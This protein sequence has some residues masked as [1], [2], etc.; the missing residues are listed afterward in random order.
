[1][2]SSQ[3]KAFHAVAATGSFT[4]AA[5]LLNVTQ[6]AVSDHV[7]KLEQATGAALFIR[8]PRGVSL[9]E[10]GKKLFALAE[11]NAETEQAVAA[12]LSQAKALEVG[13]LTIG[14]D[15]AA[16]VMPLIKKF[17]A[18]YPSVTLRIVGG[19]ST[20][21]VA[22]LQVFEIDFAV[23]G[24]PVEDAS[25]EARAISSDRLVA[26]AA[27]GSAPA[28]KASISWRELAAQPLVMREAGSHTRELLLQAFHKLAE[29][30]KVALE[31]EGREACFE[32]VAQGLGLAVVSAG[33][34]P[35]DRRI[36]AL[37]ISGSA[38]EM[39]EWLVYLKARENLRLMQ[40]LISLVP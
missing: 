34:L 20:D 10:L 30:P 36:K 9:T 32:A 26:V 39:K 25:L 19:N 13:H 22:R 38:A 2:I 28:T 12:L 31:V 40:A 18:R 21:L 4:R 23:I 24:K 29:P 17:H 15:A 8:Q 11:K 37:R 5:E 6:P 3:L 27:A 7:R 1:M 14:A 33:E 16:H 35:H